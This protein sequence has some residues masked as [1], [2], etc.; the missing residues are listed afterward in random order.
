MERMNKYQFL[1]LVFICVTLAAFAILGIGPANFVIQTA[2]AEQLTHNTETIITASLTPT[3][4]RNSSD[5]TI[6]IVV[7]SDAAG[8][9]CESRD[10]APG[11]SYTATDVE[12]IWTS[13]TSGQYH[14]LDVSGRKQ[15]IYKV[16][17]AVGNL[18]VY[19]EQGGRLILR[20]VSFCNP[21]DSCGWK[22]AIPLNWP[23]PDK[24]L[25]YTLA[26]CVW[27]IPPADD[28]DHLASCPSHQGPSGDIGGL[29]KDGINSSGIVGANV[30]ISGNG[31]TRNTVTDG[32]GRY[33]FSSF[34]A[35]NVKITASRTGYISN[36]VDAAVSANSSVQKDIPLFP[37]CSLN[38]PAC[39]GGDT[40]PPTAN[41]SNPNNG[42]TISSG[43]VHLDVT[44]Q[45]NP[46]GSGIG[47]VAFSAK[48]AG[49]WN[50][51]TTLSSGPYN[52]DWD[53]CA[54]NV[55]D[56]DIE[57]GLEAWDNTGN[58]FVWSEH[59]TNIHI[60]KDFVCAT[61]VV[62]E[63]D[64]SVSK[65][66]SPDPVNAGNNILYTL[67]VSNHGPATASNVGFADTIPDHTS[68]VEVNAPAGWSCGVAAGVLTCNRASMPLTV[69]TI[70]LT[71]K[72]NSNTAN[73]TT[74][75]NTAAVSSDTDDPD[76]S[77]NSDTQQTTV[78]NAYDLSI[79]KTASP[80]PAV[81]A[82][83][84]LTYSIKVKNNGP[85]DTV[86]AVMDDT[87]TAPLTFVSITPAAGW[88]CPTQP[89][90][91]SS[92]AVQCTKGFMTAGESG[93]FTLVVHVPA[94]VNDGNN[95]SN[96]ATIDAPGSDT[97]P[98]NDTS[99]KT[100]VVET[101][102]D[103]VITKTA[104]PDPVVIAGT[105]L[106]YQVTITNNGPSD[107]KGIKI[108]DKLA[109]YTVFKSLNTEP[110][111]WVCSKPQVGDPGTVSCTG[112]KVPAGGTLQWTL[113]VHVLPS[114]P[115]NTVLTN[116]A[117]VTLST[118]DPNLDNNDTGP[119][120]TT[121]HTQAQLTITK[122]DSPDPVIA[123]T[124]L[125]YT[126]VI[127][128][129][130]PSD[131]QNVQFTDELPHPQLPDQTTFS[132][133]AKPANWVCTTPAPG[134]NGTISCSESP[135]PF[136]ETATFQIIVQVDPGTPA[137]PMDNTAQV[138]WQDHSGMRHAE[139]TET[140]TV[141]TKAE[142]VVHKT[143]EVTGVAGA[144]TIE[145]TITIT[146][147]GPSDQL[148]VVMTDTISPTLTLLSVTPDGGGTCSGDPTITCNWAVI[149]AGQTVTVVIVAA[150]EPDALYVCN[151]ATAT[152]TDSFAPFP[153]NKSDKICQI[154]PT[155]AEASIT[156]DAKR[157]GSGRT[158]EYTIVMH[159]DGPSV[160]RHVAI[161]DK[162][163][164]A[165]DFIQ[166]T[167]TVGE[168]NY[169]VRSRTVKC[170]L[171]DLWPDTTVTMVI[172]V[173]IVKSIQTIHNKV[174]I[175]QKTFDSDKTNNRAT[176]KIPVGGGSPGDSSFLQRKERLLNL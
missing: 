148:D 117:I 111:G 52:Y 157:V 82:G 128:N 92:G 130:G 156:M 38:P 118:E 140:T 50:G 76:T 39:V 66:D 31:Q 4:I 58:Q 37:G 93:T 145:Y 132:S 68:F 55:P 155:L 23:S 101:Q 12:G 65:T 169:L 14:C 171:G 175:K 2:S 119:I 154:V 89:S 20:G 49:Q 78:N 133:L 24:D 44:A 91:G 138:D 162:L 51:I 60:Q 127:H 54:S 62:E 95:V 98:D 10:I 102:A 105:D 106:T 165:T 27:H 112:I 29:V 80:D 57:L 13:C 85:S 6:F 1:R 81:L 21:F 151:K 69:D 7:D 161:P 42:M 166:A 167:T 3:H 73:G 46:G 71:V 108:D 120:N 123:G 100:T 67:E 18:E 19:T 135:M 40:T 16:G 139:V 28:P 134:A 8:N 152:W 59:Q 79:V 11:D 147:N 103:L 129:E 168:C 88:A 94:N 64:L 33:L 113:V 63:A 131:A 70:Y 25:G 174:K 48:W 99:T 43:I 56:G 176:V 5:R 122:S 170:E 17:D 110:T 142:L 47:T 109:A 83:T 96:T 26:S 126:V 61:A 153:H 104:S 97:N 90:V 143:S 160:D 159:T 144:G 30:T 121:V 137:G 115:D 22:S 146:N 74:I 107:S 86:N 9:C 87:V 172:R 141:Q 72:V 163:S 41:W 34:P 114:T 125:I 53:V 35:G 173:K 149:E 164:R 158:I 75:S 136:D 116:N 32:T 150:M 15:R 77:N 36:S 84:D 124:Q 45:D